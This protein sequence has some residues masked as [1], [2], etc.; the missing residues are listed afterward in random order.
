VDPQRDRH[1]ES[2][3]KVASLPLTDRPTGRATPDEWA[4]RLSGPADYSSS[5]SQW[6]KALLRHWSGT[7]PDMDQ[8]PLDHHY[9]VQH[10]GG[11]K[12][13][14]RRRDGA[15]VSTVVECGSLTIVPAGTEF[16]WRTRGPIEF[17]HLYI[18]PELLLLT[19]RRFDRTNDLSLIDRVGCQDPLLQALYGSMIAEIRQTPAPDRLYLDSLLECFLLRLLHDYSTGT[20]RQPQRRETLPRFRFRRVLEFVEANLGAPVTLADLA[21]AAGGSLFHFSRAFKN[22]AGITPCN[23]LLQRR[24]ERAKV[25]LST[26]DLALSTVADACGFHHSAHFAKSFS[27][28]VG[29]T[30]TR[31]RREEQGCDVMAPVPAGLSPDSGRP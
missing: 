21:A 6:P 18:S 23:Y 7:S 26:T 28:L 25:M 19:A 31:F 29:K 5:R 17:A 3:A 4:S 20:P 11:A 10:L 24:V 1:I 13:V 15:P 8:P 16:K 9:I 22:T 27:R 12:Q 14:D 30:P 2:S